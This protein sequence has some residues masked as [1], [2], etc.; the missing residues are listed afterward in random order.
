ME[1]VM[2]T[3]NT[4]RRTVGGLL[5]L[6]VALAAGVAT[7]AVYHQ[8]TAHA[9]STMGG[10]ITRAEVLARAWN[11]FNR[12][13]ISYDASG[14]TKISDIEGTGDY[15]PDCSGFVSMAWHGSDSGG[16]YATQSL[17]N[18]AHAI[19]KSDL[20]PGDAL[21]VYATINGVL[22][23]H[24]VLF[25]TWQTDHRHFSYYSFGSDNVK[26]ATGVADQ[27]HNPNPLGDIDGST[28]DSHPLSAY[29][30]YEYNNIVDGATPQVTDLNADG[31]PDLV[32]RDSSGTL[33]AYEHKDTSAIATTSWNATLEVG[34]G[35]DIYDMIMVADLTEDGLPEIIARKPSV[36]NGAL[37]AYPHV[38][39]VTA[40]AP[41]SWGAPVEIGQVWNQFSMVTLGD[42]NND[43]DPELIAVQATTGDLVAYPH[44][45]GVTAIA[46]TSWSPSVFVGSAWNQFD[47]LSTADLDANGLPE[48][49]VRKPSLNGGSLIAYPH[50]AGVTAI[51]PASW[52]K[53][54]E[55]GRG[56]NVYS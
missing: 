10:Q 31:R 26:H 14:N 12:N 55:I 51:A 5:A 47:T 56:W 38:A 36:H 28:L 7:G 39:G 54:I 3:A 15:R 45:P 9:A 34:T 46:S 44:K 18:V 11:W 20:K 37:M 41:T 32:G 24:A 33:L 35:W 19:S 43:R 42:L 40:I 52:S 13:P 1:P 25:E 21:V 17:P 29:V 6:G 23:H 49:V 50:V 2:P 27:W 16:G 48:L 53:S 30:A 4:L 22:H 8:G